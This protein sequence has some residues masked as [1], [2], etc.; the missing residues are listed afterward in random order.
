MKLATL[1]GATRD[2][3]LVV[4]SRDLTRAVEAEEVAPSLR[5]A[6]ER[7]HEAKPALRALAI[8]VEG[9]AG[10]AFDLA[11]ALA[12]LP[13]SFQWL[14]G[15]AFASHTAL[16]ARVMDLPRDPG[17]GGVPLMYQG[18]SDPF[19]AA[20]ENVPFRAEADG[21]DVEGEFAVVVDATPMSVSADVALRHVA[22]VLLVNDWSLRS[23]AG[24]E[25]ATG[26]G[27]VQAKPPCTIAPLA[28]TPDELGADWV[29]GRVCLDLEVSVR[30]ELLGHPNGREMMFGFGE[31]IAHAAATRPLVAGTIIGSGTVSNM[32]HRSVGSSCIAERRGI[33]MLEEG[34]PRTPFLAFGDRVRLSARG[35]DG[36]DLFEAIDCAVVAANENTAT[37]GKLT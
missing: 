37:E 19:Y 34:A 24:R 9:G 17:A 3:R 22:L 18:I 11:Q 2:G 20:T 7:W 6:L 21:I 15:S 35:R 12:P 26:F 32:D 36:S 4:V 28:I 16:M 31:L 23:L 10:A 1:P 8:Q 5:V 27:Y 13:R 30:G 29:D 14:D 25:M 33:E